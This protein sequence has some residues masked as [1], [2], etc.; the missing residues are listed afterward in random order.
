MSSFKIGGT[1]RTQITYLTNVDFMETYA[2]IK[3]NTSVKIITDIASDIAGKAKGKEKGGTDG[4]KGSV[5]FRFK[6]MNGHKI[7]LFTD[8]KLFFTASDFSTFKKAREEIVSIVNRESPSTTDGRNLWL[9]L[10]KTQIETV[11]GSL[12]A[13]VSVV[14]P[15]LYEHYLSI[16]P[17]G[18]PP[19]IKEYQE[20]YL[21]KTFQG[22]MIDPSLYSAKR[23]LCR[24]KAINDIVNIMQESFDKAF[25]E[26]YER[27]PGLR[28]ELSIQLS[29]K[30]GVYTIYEEK[31]PS[32]KDLSQH[33]R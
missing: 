31:P 8:G 21:V 17:E 24:S 2:R 5:V 10:D 14:L 30:D 20:G 7:Q 16:M 27:N 6:S 4:S 26:F 29:V 19:E 9:K 23:E 1:Q 25:S 15:L 13:L 32:D 3:N 12:L 33:L 22:E 28:Y 11:K 18:V